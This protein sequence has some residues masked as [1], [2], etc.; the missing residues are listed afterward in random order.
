MSASVFGRFGRHPVSRLNRGSG[1]TFTAGTVLAIALVVSI[2]GSIVTYVSVR[3][4]FTQHVYVDQAQSDLASLYLLQLEE[5]TGLRG[6][7]SSGQ[8]LYLNSAAS[9]S[10]FNDTWQALRNASQRAQLQV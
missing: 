4:A 5:D 6:F 10:Q 9:A 7:L 3:G 1:G 8:R 2:V